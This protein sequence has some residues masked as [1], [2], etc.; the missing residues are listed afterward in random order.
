MSAE[1]ALLFR[2]DH[3]PDLIISDVTMGE[4]DGF[5]LLEKI[6]TVAEM[7]HIP[8]VFLTGVQDLTGV[9]KAKELGAS[10]Y[11]RKPVE[12]DDVLQTVREILPAS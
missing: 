3:T 12:L 5:T 4:M 7:K 8:F 6:H 2:N 11:I 10:A 1:D 9:R